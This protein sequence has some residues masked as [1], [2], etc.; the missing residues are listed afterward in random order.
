VIVHPS[1]SPP[2]IIAGPTA[3][4]KSQLALAVAQRVPAEIIVADSMQ[5]YCGL[6]IATDKPTLRERAAVPH[7]LLDI[8]EPHESFSA[9]AFAA[10]ART[11]VDS[12]QRRGK[13]PILVGGTGL[14]LRAFL[15]GDLAGGGGD[16]TL[17]ARLK[18]EATQIGAPALHAR[19]A[20]RDPVSAQAIRPGDLFR[21]IRALELCETTG[22]TA[23]TLRP[24]LWDPPRRPLAGFLVLTRAREELAQRIALR[25]ARMWDAGLLEEVWALL[26]RGVPPECRALQSIGYRQA[27]AV[28]A[29]RMTLE[30]AQEDL[31]RATRQ[32]AKRQ[33]TWFRREPAAEW[34]TVSGDDWADSLADRL[35]V[36]WGT[37]AHAVTGCA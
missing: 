18:T 37:A 17:R 33:L 31:V 21:I 4:G 26:A 13:L 29:G 32:Y 1:A 15:K 6:D 11:A 14:Y 28:L 5:V 35:A 25:S 20:A 9:F 30:A 3:V 16:S 12:T 19:L 10:A 23:S 22:Q 8:C 27:V 34:I 2:V 36:R 24:G 7:H